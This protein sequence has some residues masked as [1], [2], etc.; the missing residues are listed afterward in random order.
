ME[1]DARCGLCMGVTAM[2]LD[3]D[4]EGKLH[5]KAGLLAQYLLEHREMV[6]VVED[7]YCPRREVA[8]KREELELPQILDQQ[9]EVIPVRQTIR[10]ESSKIADVTY[11][12]DFPVRHRGDGIQLELPGQFQVLWYDK[13]GNLQSS[14][15]RTEEN[16]DAPAGENVRINARVFPGASPMAS[17][18][19][20]IELKG[21][22]V[23]DVT[24]C[25]DS[26]LPMVAGLTIGEEDIRDEGRPSVILRRAGNAGLWQIAKSTGS[27]VPAIQKANALDAEPSQER[28][29][30]IPV[31]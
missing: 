14:T 13:E 25:S 7:A 26:G 27:T 31:R 22:T 2:E 23:L 15:A 11:L 28:I 24:A 19:S 16:W 9:R 3:P 21:E 30:L 17:P 12:P 5:L 8:L 1:Q 10:Q 6:E 4:P 20:G 18:G 29:L